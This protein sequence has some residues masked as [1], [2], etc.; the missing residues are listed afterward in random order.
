MNE[1]QQVVFL[2]IAIVRIWLYIK[3]LD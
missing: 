2:A 1:Y 3:K